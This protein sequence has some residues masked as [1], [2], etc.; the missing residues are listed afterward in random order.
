MDWSEYLSKQ[1]RGNDTLVAHI[2][3]REAA[4]LKSMG[5]S[6]TRNPKTGLLE[7]E[8][9]GATAGGD[10]GMGGFD[11]GGMSG[12]GTNARGGL[13]DDPAAGNYGGWG[14]PG[15]AF[16][17]DSLSD[18]SVFDKIYSWFDDLSLK[19]V[20][21][22]VLTAGKIGVNI[23]TGNIP[24]VMA[25]VF[26]GLTGIPSN[27]AMAAIGVMGKEIANSTP[28]GRVAA[29]QAAHESMVSESLAGK[30]G[31]VGGFDIASTQLGETIQEKSKVLDD[32]FTQYGEVGNYQ[33]AVEAA[34]LFENKAATKAILE[35]EISRYSTDPLYKAVEPEFRV[36]ADAAQEKGM[37]PKVAAEYAFEKVK[38]AYTARKYI[39][40][41]LDRKRKELEATV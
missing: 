21:K 22:G 27:P 20:L 7:F 40:E 12:M 24:G 41:Y 4:I 2:S 25:G 15:S 11:D 29:N 16:S 30:P 26:T 34:K 10:D 18:P 5:G 6:G 19:D 33:G 35:A 17:D 39:R 3:P 1:G 13:G 36:L 8:E 9:S 23:A 31:E 38:E 32:L 37:E 28:E 14:D